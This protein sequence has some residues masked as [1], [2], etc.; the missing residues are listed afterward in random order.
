MRRTAAAIAGALLLAGGATAQPG[1]TSDEAVSRFMERLV[2][3]VEA[4]HDILARLI[5]A[6]ARAIT[7]LTGRR[8]AG[9][10]YGRVMTPALLRAIRAHEA[11]LVR[12]SCGGRYARDEI[13]GLNHS[14]ITCAGDT[15]ESFRFIVRRTVRGW[16]V[17]MVV[18]DGVHA[19]HRVVR[20][21]GDLRLDAVAC[22]DGPAFNG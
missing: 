12:R 21:G 3:R 11:G 9:G 8:I 16:D 7:A 5:P 15:I 17:E 1:P 22:R 13:C 18:E 10:G 6:R 4:D 20:N 2:A 19:R 14:P